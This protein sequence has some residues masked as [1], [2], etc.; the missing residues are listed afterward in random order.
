[1]MPTAPRRTTRLLAL[2][3][4][5]GVATAPLDGWAQDDPPGTDAAPQTPPP[6]SGATGGITLNGNYKVRDLVEYF[7]RVLGDNYILEGGERTLQEEVSIIS[8]KPVSPRVAQQA[9]VA[10]LEMAG[11]TLV[12]VNGTKQIIK[13]GEASQHPIFVGEGDTLPASDAR[14]VTQIL[15]LENVQVSDVQSVVQSLSSTDAKVIAYQPAN[16][17]IITDTVPNLRKV[18]K[19]LSQLDVA[20]PRSRLEIIPLR[21]AQATEVASLIQ[22]LFTVGESTGAEPAPTTAAA[23][24]RA[25]RAATPEPT[26][27]ITAGKESSYISKVMPDERTNSLLVLANDEGFKAIFSLLR[28]I[29]VDVDI[30]S[31]SQIHVVYLQHAKAEDIAGVLSNLSEGGGASG[32]TAARRT[33]AAA[34]AA[35]AAARRGADTTTEEA[36]GVIAAFDSG[37]R[38]THDEAT[39]SLVIIASNEDFRVVES[40]ISKLDIRRKQVFVD[41]VILE[42][43]SQ[44]TDQFGVAYHGPLQLGDTVGFWGSQLGA[45]SL[46]LT[47]DLLS[48]VAAGVFGNG[49]EVP[50]S[51]P[52]GVQNITIPAF[53]IV[54]SALRA[55]SLISIVSNPNLL[56][57]D[58]EEAKIIVG[59]RIP[60]PT[61]SGLN[62]LGQPVVSY[63]REDVAT[64]LTITPRI[65]SSNEVTLEIIAS[66]SEIEEDNQGLDVNQAGF[67]TSKREI[68][69]SALVRNNQTMVLGGLVGFTDTEIETKVPILGDLPLI[70][71]LFRGTRKEARRTNLMIFLT[72][73]IIEDEDDMIEVHRVKEA[74]RQEFLR[75][76]YGRSREQQMEQIRELLSYS[77]NVVDEPSMYRGGTTSGG[78]LLDGE[79]L[80]DETRRA[81]EDSLE[82]YERDPGARA[83]T[84]DEGSGPTIVL[85]P[86]PL[87]DQ[88]E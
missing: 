48:G 75:R 70:G 3:L 38:I 27:S 44:D 28:E 88:E 43:G 4:S 59:R 5:I 34:P 7:A 60:F 68:E 18:Q 36:R 86:G 17:L 84:L 21:F 23:R 49:I 79:P 67:I 81:I 74:Q 35:T 77:M 76:F 54:V 56:T 71:M 1:M 14:Y 46:G 8:H 53:G 50:F 26:E 11:Y 85:P 87:P 47:Q 41:A 52:M 69:T 64:E 78:V 42:I 57:L 2:A 6:I 25:R 65:N 45:S 24:R 37:M 63:Q 33:T 22:E 32:S 31:R 20:A 12:D 15:Q 16:T 19:I 30:S 40:V 82:S 29:D 80:S 10:A 39:N 73:H 58:N 66:V 55:N 13:T 83:G 72:P 51:T 9:F 61:S 62:S